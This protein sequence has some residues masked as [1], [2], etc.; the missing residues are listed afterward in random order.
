MERVNSDLVR[1]FAKVLSDA[2]AEAGISQEV[3]AER[4]NISTR[5]V[6][7]LENGARQPTLTILHALCI[8]LGVPMSDFVRRVDD[9]LKS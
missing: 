6:S 9:C 3:L 5:H 1:A 4:A 2:R 8:G 7:Y